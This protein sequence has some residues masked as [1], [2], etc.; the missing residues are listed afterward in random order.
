MK[1]TFN[2]HL[3]GRATSDAELRI[4]GKEKR[5]VCKFRMMV[6]SGKDKYSGEYMEPFWFSVTCWGDRARGIKKGMD[7]E[8]FGYMKREMY[9]KAGEKK[10][11]DV[12][13]VKTDEAGEPQL[14]YEGIPSKTKHVSDEAVAQ[15]VGNSVP[16]N[17]EITDDDIPF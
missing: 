12:V 4:V 3:V 15:S 6:S 17:L 1:P 2:I 11:V 7:V 5:P 13:T 10:T 8:L 16:N 14:N 9:E